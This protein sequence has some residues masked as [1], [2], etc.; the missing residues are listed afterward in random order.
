MGPGTAARLKVISFEK[1]PVPQL[2][3][4]RTLKQYVTPEVKPAI[5]VL[6]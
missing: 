6:D 4:A 5:V 2:L 1:L 3:E